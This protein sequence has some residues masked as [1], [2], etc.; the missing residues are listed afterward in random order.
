[1]AVLFY[2]V[3]L[4]SNLGLCACWAVTVPLRYT[5]ALL[6]IDFIQRSFIIQCPGVGRLVLGIELRF[7][8]FQANNALLLSYVHSLLFTFVLR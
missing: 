4:R 1:M 8:T 7:L 3:V 6:N 5:L 2:F